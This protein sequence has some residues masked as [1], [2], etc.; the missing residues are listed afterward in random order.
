MAGMGEGVAKDRS[1]NPGRKAVRVAEWE[2]RCLPLR[3][4][5]RR[6]QPLDRYTQVFALEL[7]SFGKWCS[8]QV[9]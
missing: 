6:H 5:R 1:L 9:I 7:R 3:A 2:G 4:Y 8:G